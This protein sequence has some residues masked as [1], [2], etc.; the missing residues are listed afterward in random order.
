MGAKFTRSDRLDDG[1]VQRFLKTTSPM[2]S[3][4]GISGN[5]ITQSSA[6]LRSSR[7]ANSKAT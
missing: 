1:G 2:R 3:P 6:P 7:F 5:G 4:T